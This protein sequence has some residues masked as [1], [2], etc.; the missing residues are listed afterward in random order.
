MPSWAMFIDVGREP[1]SVELRQAF[2]FTGLR[3]KIVMPSWA[4]FIDNFMT[5]P[6]T[7]GPQVLAFEGLRI[8]FEKL[9]SVYIFGYNVEILSG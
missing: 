8:I 5:S 6:L 4:M 9:L 7:G 2:S 1:S 3:F